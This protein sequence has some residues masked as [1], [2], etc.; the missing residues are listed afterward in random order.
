MVDEFGATSAGVGA[1]A[2][3]QYFGDGGQRPL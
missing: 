3:V 2:V 1:H